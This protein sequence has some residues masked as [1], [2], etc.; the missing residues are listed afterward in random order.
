MVTSPCQA[1]CKHGGIRELTP[2]IFSLKLELHDEH[3]GWTKNLHF[4]PINKKAAHFSC[5]RLWV[6]GNLKPSKNAEADL[7]QRRKYE[8]LQSL[9]CLWSLHSMFECAQMQLL[10]AEPGSHDTCR[11]CVYSLVL[12]RNEDL[13]VLLQPWGWTALGQFFSH[14]QPSRNSHLLP[15]RSSCYLLV[16]HGNSARTEHKPYR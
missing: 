10:R 14:R 4:N 5:S 13:H 15:E 8:V 7:K 11:N 6:S 2:Y 12:R 9:L 16:S 1:F 3:E